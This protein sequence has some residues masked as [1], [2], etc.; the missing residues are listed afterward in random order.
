VNG[1]RL[2]AVTGSVLPLVGVVGVLTALG[3]GEGRADSYVFGSLVVALGCAS[4][5]LV[6]LRGF[7]KQALIGLWVAAM[8]LVAGAS[9]GFALALVHPRVSQGEQH[10]TI[11]GGVSRGLAG[12]VVLYPALVVGAVVVQ[13]AATWIARRVREAAPAVLPELADP[14]RGDQA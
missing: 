14:Q 3:T 6:D 10:S 9:T 7:P 8:P 2:A 12:G 5:A 13:L 11:L 1:P 4:V